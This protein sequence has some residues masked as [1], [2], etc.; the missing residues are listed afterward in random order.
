VFLAERELRIF[1][2]PPGRGRTSDRFSLCALRA[3]NRRARRRYL[4]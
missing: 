1:S 2:L 4:A 3:N